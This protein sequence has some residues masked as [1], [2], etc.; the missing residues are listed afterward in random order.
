MKTTITT[1]LIACCL[2]WSDAL[3]A[4]FQMGTSQ[5]TLVDAGRNN[6][7]LPLN[8]YYPSSTGGSN[9]TCADGVFPYVVIAHGFSMQPTNYVYLS[10]HLAANG[11]IVLA[12]GTETGFFP[13]HENY[14][15][16]I[17]YVANHFIEENTT[18]GSLF[19]S[20]VDASCAAIGHSMGGGATFLAASQAGVA[21]NCIIGMAAAET[22]PSA[23]SASAQI[24]IPVMVLSGTT[25]AVTAPESNHV[26][27]YNGAASTCKVLQHIVNGSHCG[28]ADDGNLCFLGEPAFAG[29][30]Y[31]TQ[32]D[33]AQAMTLDWLDFHL[34]GI[35]AAWNDIS[36]FDDTQSNTETEISCVVSVEEDAES[37]SWS[38]YPNPASTNISI[39]RR[40]ISIPA[41]VVIAD[42]DGRIVLRRNMKIGERTQRIYL[43]QLTPG[44]YVLRTTEG[45]RCLAQRLLIVR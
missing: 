21:L 33:I 7:S 13:S 45:S 43:D 11:Y 19:E 34:K 29:L 41:T 18:A 22:T 12:L 38:V 28:F 16:D 40:D 17:A 30:D 27:M 3:H 6:R 2:F 15:L 37:L 8:V 9:A 39:E 32:R 4:Q 26:P 5:M 31:T 10:E 42:A 35:H 36:T 1:A 23:I 25:D 44:V 14:G 20:H 24:Q